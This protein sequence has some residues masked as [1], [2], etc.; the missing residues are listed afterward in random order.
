M[1]RFRGKKVLTKTLAGVLS[2]SMVIGGMALDNSIKVYAGDTLP[3]QGKSARGVNQPYQ[4][5][6][7]G[8][9]LLSWSYKTDPY[10]ELLRARV[11]L[12]NRNEAFA[13]TQAHPNL[14]T[15]PEYFT[16]TGDYGNAFFDSYPYTNEFSQHL[17]N[18]WQYVDYYGS[19][20]GMPTEEVPQRLYNSD[21]ERNGTS[22]WQQRSFEFGM[23][24][25]PNPGYTNAAHKNGVLSIGCI[26][27]PRAYQHFDTLLVQDE[28]GNFPCADKLVEI[29]RYFGFDGWFFNM[30]G[31]SISDEQRELLGKFFAQ[32]RN[33]GLYIQWYTAD[34]SFSLSNTAPLLTSATEGNTE[35]AQMRAQSVFL[36]YNWRQDAADN[37]KKVGLDPYKAVFGGIEAG[38]NRWNNNYDK[39][40]DSSGNMVMSIAS[41]GTDFVQ[42]GFYEN[43]MQR[44]EDEYQ[45]I[46][47]DRER[48]W[49]T[50][51][52]FDPTVT[53]SV[54]D[55]GR[56]D[57]D[58]SS[59][60]FK[61]VANYIAERSAINGDVFETDFNTGHGLEYR[62]NG[63]VSSSAEWSNINVQDYL[64]TWQWWI[65]SESGNEIGADFDY[66]VANW[67]KTDGSAHELS[68][69]QV[70]AYDG[71]SSLVLYGKV[72]S[73][74]YVRLYKTDLSVQAS[75]DMEI[76]YKKSSEDAA[77]LMLSLVFKDNPEETVD[78]PVEGSDEKGDW[79]TAKISLSDHA[80]RSIASIGLK[81]TG[82]ADD[83]QINI[84]KLRLSNGSAVAPDAPTGVSV[85]EAYD[86]GEMVVTWDIAPYDQVQEYNI[87]ANKDGKKIWLGGTYD[88]IFY[89]KDTEGMA[90][91]KGAGVLGIEI[92]PA[93]AEVEKGGSIAF[94]AKE[95]VED[96]EAGKVTIE[97]CAVGKDGLESSGAKAS[98][99]FVNAPSNVSV[100]ATDGNL[101]VTWDG[102]YGD[103]TVTTSCEEEP[104]TWTGSGD[105]SCDIAVA[106]GKEADGARYKLTISNGNTFTNY[107]GRLDDS[108]SAPYDGKVDPER[109]C[110]TG[111]S[112]RDWYVLHYWYIDVD[113]EGN[114]T[115]GEE[116]TYTRGKK[117]HGE[118]NNDWSVFQ[119]IGDDVDKIAVVLEDYAGNM[120]EEVVIGN[121]T[122][123]K[124]ECSEKQVA[125]GGSLSFT[126]KVSNGSENEEENAVVW[127]VSGSSDK[128]NTKIDETGLL[129]VSEKETAQRIK[130]RASLA[131]DKKTYGE[132]EIA[133]VP[134][135]TLEAESESVYKGEQAQFY[136]K[137]NLTSE[138]LDAAGFTWSVAAERAY[139]YGDLKD[140]GANTQVS[141]QGIL[142]VDA[143]EQNT[144]L[145]V[146]A[147]DE[148]G[149]R[150]EKTVKVEDLYQITSLGND[151]PRRG[152]KVQFAIVN[153]KTN[154]AVEGTK[155]EWTVAASWWG[156][157]DS[158][159]KIDENG[160][161]HI[162]KNE[163][164]Y[165]V[166]VKAKDKE[167]GQE[168]STICYV[169]TWADPIETDDADEA[170]KN[171][172]ETDHEVT[173]E[174]TPEQDPDG[175][176]EETQNGEENKDQEADP[177]ADPDAAPEENPDAQQ[178]DNS[179]ENPDNAQG[180]PSENSEQK[181]DTPETP[182]NAEPS[183]D[184]ASED[185]KVGDGSSENG[186][187]AGESLSSDSSNEES[188]ETVSVNSDINYA[189][190]EQE[191]TSGTITQ[192]E[193]KFIWS[194]EGASSKG[195]RISDDGVLTVAADENAKTLTVS[196]VYA[197][198]TQLKAS[199]TVTVKEKSKDNEKD[200][201]TENESKEGTTTE[202][203]TET[204]ITVEGGKS[205]TSDSGETV[206]TSKDC[207]SV[208]LVKAV[209][210]KKTT[211]AATVKIGGKELPVT[212]IG[213]KASGSKAK[214]IVID[215]ANLTKVKAKAFVNSKKAT[216]IVVKN[217]KEES[218]VGK[219]IIKAANKLAKKSGK[220][221]KVV[222]K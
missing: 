31:R 219:Q 205:Y 19:W 134:M 123:I 82:E 85:K 12:Q 35:D 178:G 176:P 93:Q 201:K 109:K 43:T 89:V 78:I 65:T 169:D 46:A 163:S 7:R 208:T 193:S 101:H 161:L 32:M 190:V 136:V 88:D 210:K 211:F 28:D 21:G 213:S 154:E 52:S 203:G 183:D 198:N 27:Q 111:P 204:E 86:T 75:S 67:K 25:L 92:T 68:Y 122:T 55:A 4:H 167:S 45:W 124:V 29:C 22:D 127:S 17:F 121:R 13:A 110:F 214:K 131:T 97:V 199:A 129:T 105:G 30:E 195:T 51:P 172:D 38:G 168:F 177:E 212:V 138:K 171:G 185:G 99:D 94:S 95:L 141:E 69:D 108:Y 77:K 179:G 155:F 76:T 84:G 150:F 26:F 175:T 115:R 187:A 132:V 10:A 64:P 74:N 152:E 142:T 47:F 137:N 222:F 63:T 113:D 216:K 102:G 107:Q 71:G 206:K 49:W 44:E 133:I 143:A 114:E 56:S 157:L 91:E 37:A 126:A 188:T 23:M 170:D 128:E 184:T 18:F 59:G 196:V 209:N 220:K 53:Q 147:V 159:T 186:N 14:S 73:E 61:G 189:S 202:S 1:K 24:N 42:T 118:L 39:F 192:N 6:Y 182:D 36:D 9:D 146:T 149:A 60:S 90:S 140:L 66:G 160:L 217:V 57:I 96:I 87:Y 148:S 48:M 191:V 8:E 116:G 20:H 33:E 34:G 221:V 103:V 166:N 50:G 83:Y 98:H 207:K 130:V 117:S 200:N 81:V 106:S 62:K 2:A 144:N 139:Y 218:K 72:D 54:S 100:E 153:K 145:K 70:G 174:T 165:G 194:V 104:R 151:Y 3:Y 15:A 180:Q 58:A 181:E 164:S 215:G 79:N 80:G 40:L 162:S 119:T 135:Y 16:L 41:L 173:P 197:D 112:S 11:P 156:T 125:A 120:S 5:G 158:E